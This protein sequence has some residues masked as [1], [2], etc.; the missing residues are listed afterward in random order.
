MDTLSRV[1]LAVQ[2]LCVI[3]DILF[4]MM[5]AD[6]KYFSFT[7][8]YAAH[9]NKHTIYVDD[10]VDPSILNR[11]K[12]LLKMAYCGARL[13]DFIE[14]KNKITNGQVSQAFSDALDIS[15]KVSEIRLVPQ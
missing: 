13:G 9:S 3:E 14:H 8:G 4:L 15:L 7:Q 2:E 6:G 5:S 11:V 12:P 10:G 1:P